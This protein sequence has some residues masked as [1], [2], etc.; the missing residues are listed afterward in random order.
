MAGCET[1]LVSEQYESGTEPSEPVGWLELFFDLVVVVS[2]AVLA[3]H[4]L[5]HADLHGV[6]RFALLYAA[7]WFVWTQS[8]LYANV[9]AANIRIGVMLLVMAGIAVMAAAIPNL[10]EHANAFAVGFLLCR[11]LVTR[12]SMA[13][14]KVLTSWPTL[15]QGGTMLLWFA[16]LWVDTPWKY[17]LWAVSLAVDIV[18]A[19]LTGTEDETRARQLIERMTERSRK[20]AEKH[21]HSGRGSRQSRRPMPDLS[22][23]SL[24]VEHRGLPCRR[25]V[26]AAV[27]GGSAVRRLPR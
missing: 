13:T 22:V 17:V 7:I 24:R 26:A 5:E 25:C 9:A 11:L 23:A 21:G 12:G 3:E 16:S 10:D 8:V 19:I 15:Q 4:L 1:A 6:A 2:M 27:A 14:G 18:I 20:Q